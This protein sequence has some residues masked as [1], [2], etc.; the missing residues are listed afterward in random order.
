MPLLHNQAETKRSTPSLPTARPSRPY[1]QK[2][3]KTLA[4]VRPPKR[5]RDRP[6]DNDNSYPSNTVVTG[7]AP[8]DGADGPV[9]PREEVLVTPI[10]EAEGVGEA[11]R[12]PVL[13][14]AL[15]PTLT[16]V[17]LDWIEEPT[18][19]CQCYPGRDTT[20][21]W[22][23]P[24]ARDELDPCPERPRVV[25][26]GSS[27]ESRARGASCPAITTRAARASP[28]KRPKEETRIAL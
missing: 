25:D 17:G 26:E 15:P 19:K 7:A 5:H 20:A 12:R 24:I 27:R 16:W 22:K 21:I 6:D 28:R 1:T 13:A 11:A 23:P 8:V 10:A 2:T 14:P 18:M 9:G 4:A 3:A